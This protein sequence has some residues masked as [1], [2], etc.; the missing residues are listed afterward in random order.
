MFID[1]HKCRQ[2]L[3]LYSKTATDNEALLSFGEDDFDE[4]LQLLSIH[5]PVLVPLIKNANPCQRAYAPLLRALSTLSP[6][7]ALIVPTP[8]NLELVET[9]IEGCEVRSN[10]DLWCRLQ[11]NIPIIFKLMIDLNVISIPEVV[12]PIILKMKEVAKRPYEAVISECY[13][14]VE[15]PVMTDADDCC[16]YPNL[17][18]CR[19]RGYYASDTTST[20][21]TCT[22]VHRGHPS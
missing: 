2:L 22:K 20:V 1:H 9:L 14:T 21:S 16:Y 6:V 3:L 17:P 11:Y 10:P 15:P 18:K 8:S 4:L 5:S 19:E 7:C 13:D 12:R